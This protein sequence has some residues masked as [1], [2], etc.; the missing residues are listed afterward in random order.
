[1]G[2]SI[3]FVYML[4]FPFLINTGCCIRF[5]GLASYASPTFFLYPGAT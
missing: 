1:M 3:Y 4:E 2:I 5:N